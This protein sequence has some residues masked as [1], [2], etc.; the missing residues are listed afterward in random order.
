M[1]PSL[2]A[3]TSATAS[4][5]ARPTRRVRNG[6]IL[7]VLLGLVNLPFLFMPTPDGEDGPPY[8][9]LVASAVLGVLSIV[10]AVIAWRTGDRRAIRVTAACV[11]INA[12]TTLPAL[13]ADVDP[14]IKV[15]GAIYI[16]ASIAA[17]VL[18]LG[19][20]RSN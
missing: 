4:T 14:G 20:R 7:S 18:L 16:L 5:P 10:T 8:G 13:F 12:V 9:V 19:R 2:A 6:L 17:L 1:E 3:S 15:F 11:I